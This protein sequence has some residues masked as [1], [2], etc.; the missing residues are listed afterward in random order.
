[1]EGR[2]SIYTALVFIIHHY[3]IIPP[4]LFEIRKFKRFKDLMADNPA[5]TGTTRRNILGAPLGW[6]CT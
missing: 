4:V 3:S 2:G 5:Q 1:M 6:L